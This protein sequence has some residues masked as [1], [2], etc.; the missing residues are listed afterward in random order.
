MKT[1]KQ[2]SKHNAL[3]PMPL[4][5]LLFILAGAVFGVAFIAQLPGE[6]STFDLL[7]TLVIWGI[8]FCLIVIG[9]R[10]NSSRHSAP[11]PRHDTRCDW[12]DDH[13]FLE[14]LHEIIH[15]HH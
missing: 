3:N 13:E 6:W 7:A 14:D 2:H 1:R 11:A 5:I 4:L 12:L 10:G 15:K 9:R 8:A